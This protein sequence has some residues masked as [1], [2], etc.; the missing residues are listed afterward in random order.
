[1]KIDFSQ[2]KQIVILTGAGISTASG[3][4]TY[5]GKNGIW[6]KYNIEEY[7]HVDRLTDHPEK[8]WTLF[9]ALRDELKTAQPNAAHYA[10]AELEKTRT[11]FQ[12]FTLITQNIDRLHQQAGSQN[13]IECHGN[14]LHT[15]CSNTNCD[16]QPYIDDNSH[17]NK[18]PLCPNCHNPLRP[19]I[20]LFGEMIPN[21]KDWLIK[22]ALRNCDLFISIGTSGSVYPA[23]SF[24]RSAE[25]AGARTIC[26]NL[27]PM[28]PPNPAFK[29]EYL[30]KA[31]KILP[32]MFNVNI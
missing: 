22:H 19:D 5:R 11:P 18:I 23:A 6:E 30:G 26:I 12:E 3:L 7:G 15:K 9:G 29:E 28:S 8:I 21:D 1:M 16:L 14:I 31:E 13:V 24:V 25:Y 20:V 27:D 4:H 2:Y 32:D 17:Q 10:L